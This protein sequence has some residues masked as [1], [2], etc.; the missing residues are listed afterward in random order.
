MIHG[1][2]WEVHHS[3]T[4]FLGLQTVYN[5]RRH[6]KLGG[7]YGFWLSKERCWRWQKLLMYH[8]DPIKEFFHDIKP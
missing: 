2:E 4:V 6:S 1:K 8:H 5:I 3:Y 7:A